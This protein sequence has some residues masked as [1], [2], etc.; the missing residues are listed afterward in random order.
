[1]KHIL[2]IGTVSLVTF[3]AIAMA[4]CGNKPEN[5][6]PS[7]SISS[8]ALATEDSNDILGDVKE[9]TIGIQREHWK[10]AKTLKEDK[11]IAA[12]VN[13]IPIYQSE[14]EIKMS[15]NIGNREI[16]R[17]QLE[18]MEISAQEK[19]SAWEN[20]TSIPLP[21][22]K[23]ILNELIREIVIKLQADKQNLVPTEEEALS[24]AQEHF[25]LINNDPDA[26]KAFKFIWIL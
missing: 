6:E 9:I 2:K 21:D 26:K 13:G 22:R 25:A 10:K 20:Y 19:T 23:A 12:T 3:L 4:G 14:I 15:E 8:S 16:Y 5:S 24:Y 1:M 7:N 17:I 18:S 11:T